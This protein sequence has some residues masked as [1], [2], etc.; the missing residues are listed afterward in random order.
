MNGYEATKLIRESGKE[1]AKSIKIIA[2]TADVLPRDIENAKN[3]G[4]DEHIGKPIQPQYVQKIF[5][6]FFEKKGD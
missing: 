4:M 3:A 2:M 5:D 1:D 6:K